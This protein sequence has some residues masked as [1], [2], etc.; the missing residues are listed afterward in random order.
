MRGAGTSNYGAG[1]RMFFKGQ[2]VYNNVLPGPA[3]CNDM[4]RSYN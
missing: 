3:S 4:V 1:T 2:Q